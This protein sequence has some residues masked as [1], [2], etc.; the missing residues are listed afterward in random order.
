MATQSYSVPS[1]PTICIGPAFID[2]LDYVKTGHKLNMSDECT[3]KTEQSGHIP[4][5]L[6]KQKSLGFDTCEQKIEM[7]RSP[8]VSLNILENKNIELQSTF[9]SIIFQ[10]FLG[11]GIQLK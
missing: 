7:R 9:S 2:I 11:V 3:Q 8:G 6:Q 1:K 10:L 4:G 5:Y